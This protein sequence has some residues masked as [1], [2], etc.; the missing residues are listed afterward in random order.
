MGNTLTFLRN[1][2]SNSTFVKQFKNFERYHR[3]KQEITVFIEGLQGIYPLTVLAIPRKN[4]NR[5]KFL[6]NFR[7]CTKVTEAVT[8]LNETSRIKMHKNIARYRLFCRVAKR[9]IFPY[10]TL[11]LLL[12]QA[13]AKD[14]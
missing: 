2:R 1:G 5:M 13:N 14:L 8:L 9:S 12:G 4:L 11:K 3:R 10:S 7:M 6:Q